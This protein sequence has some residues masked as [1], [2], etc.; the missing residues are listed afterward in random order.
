[1]NFS[2]WADKIKISFNTLFYVPL[3]SEQNEMV[4]DL[5]P[6]FINKRGIY[7]DSYGSSHKF[8]DYQLRPNLCIAMAVA[9]ELFE[10]KYA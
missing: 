9:P 3:E 1:L 2:D 4:F 8:T 7:K 6:K 5:E 10:R